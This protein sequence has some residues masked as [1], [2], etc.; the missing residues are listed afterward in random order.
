MKDVKNVI[1]KAIAEKL[2]DFP[3]L[4]IAVQVSQL[5][6]CY[7]LHRSLYKWTEFELFRIAKLFFVQK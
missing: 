7:L 3:N 6:S 4:E 1:D 2:I 5:V